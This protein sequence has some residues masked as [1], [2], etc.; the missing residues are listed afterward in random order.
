MAEY[1]VVPSVSEVAQELQQEI[2][3]KSNSTLESSH[4]EEQQELSHSEQVDVL[5]RSG[6]VGE[7]YAHLFNRSEY[8][9]TLRNEV[10]HE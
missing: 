4:H 9:S 3:H 6:S 7:Q 8:V 1:V 10:D 2:E 5:L